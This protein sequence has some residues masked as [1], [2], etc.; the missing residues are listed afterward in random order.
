MENWSASPEGI[1]AAAEVYEELG[2]QYS[3][4]VVAS[5]L[6]R[7][8][9]EIALRVEQ[10]LA[11]A[12]FRPDAAP[13]TDQPSASDSQR[14]LLRGLAIGF[15]TAVIPLLWFWSLGSRST[16][17]NLGRGLVVLASV[18]IAVTCAVRGFRGNGRRGARASA[19]NRS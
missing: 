5:F 3:D 13:R 17:Q 4:A 6:D 10:R 8:D 11:N 18:A 9:K 15:G 14:G 2:P 12:G 16:D 19:P 7:V 1:R